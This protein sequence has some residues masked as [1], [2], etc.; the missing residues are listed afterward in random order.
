MNIELELKKLIKNVLNDLDLEEDIIIE[1]PKDRSNGDYSSNVAMKCC[2]KLGKSPIEIANLVKNNISSD[3]IESIE[4]KNP[5][6]INFFVNKTYLFEE[7]KEIIKLENNYGKN[8]LGEHKKVNIEFVSVNPTGTIHLGH[9]RGACIGD[10]LANILSFNGYDV[11]KE[12]YI[13]DAGNQMINMALSIYERYKEICGLDFQMKENYY[14]G[15]EIIEVAQKMYD[16]KKDGYL[17]SDIKVFWKKSLEYFLGG[18]KK[19]L[20]N[21]G[22]NFDVWT[23]EQ[24]LRDRNLVEEA[25]SKLTSLGYTYEQDGAIF[26]KTTL[27]GDEK[28]R[29]LVKQDKSYTYFMPDIA[30]H[31]DKLNHGY[32]SRLKASVTMLG[33]DA[34]K[35]SVLLIQMV[36]AIKNGEEYKISK[37]T[38]NTITLNDLVE[39]SGKDAIRY[40]FTSRSMDTQMDF[41]IDLAKKNSNEN[42]VFYVN[43]AHARICSILR[44]QDYALKEDYKFETIDSETAYNVLE[45][46]NEFKKVVKKSAL[47]KEPHLITNYVYEL[48]TVFHSYYSEEK[49]VTDNEKYTYE[50]IMLIKAVKIII[51]NSLNLIGVAPAERM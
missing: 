26:L 25:L 40:F 12:Y 44:N 8:N 5:G 48:A 49:I 42:P 6:F 50:R 36:R 27:F 21:I 34:D 51:A 32:V 4:I 47:K 7:L 29:V 46:L 3:L 14:Y 10:S 33:Q 28:D 45:K 23:S 43:Y 39:E 9:A 37:R 16:E 31:L 38:G 20:A 41:D 30:Y 24:E 18:I 17:T 35:L 15:K 1:I 11:T 22:V 19:D 13:N 2:K